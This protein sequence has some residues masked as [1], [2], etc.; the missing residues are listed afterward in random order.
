MTW[1]GR[2][3]LNVRC[4]KARDGYNFL[5]GAIGQGHG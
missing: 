2:H 1:A 4:L 5:G 3:E